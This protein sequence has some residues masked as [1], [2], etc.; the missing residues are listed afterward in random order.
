[1]TFMTG[2]LNDSCISHKKCNVLYTGKH[3]NY[4]LVVQLSGD[5]LEAMDEAK[6][7]GVIIESDLSFH[8]RIY[9]MVARA[10][11]VLR[12]ILIT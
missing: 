3:N 1:M 11:V 6:D 9:K 12:S 5:S 4:M 10:L 2:L 8:S 7:L